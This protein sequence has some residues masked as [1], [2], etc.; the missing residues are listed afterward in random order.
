MNEKFLSGTK[1]PNKQTNKQT[2]L[3][4]KR[5]NQSTPRYDREEVHIRGF[6][7]DNVYIRTFFPRGTY[8]H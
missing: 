6:E 2:I 8:L 3:F 4:F 1:N 7:L 5:E